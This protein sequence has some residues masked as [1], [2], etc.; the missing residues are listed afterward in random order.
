[1][2]AVDHGAVLIYNSQ[3]GTVNSDITLTNVKITNTRSTASR[4]AGVINSGGVNQRLKFDAFNISAGPATAFYSNTG[5][6][7]YN[8]TGWIVDGNSVGDLIGWS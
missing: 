7:A 6:G 8:R 3:P 2:S 4:N 5:D 1:E